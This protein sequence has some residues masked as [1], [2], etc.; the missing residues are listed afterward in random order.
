MELQEMSVNGGHIFISPYFEGMVSV[1]EEFNLSKEGVRSCSDG[2]QNLGGFLDMI[3]YVGGKDCKPTTF[4]TKEI[5]C[6]ADFMNT[7]DS[8]VTL[9]LYA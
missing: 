4:I 2:D 8:M 6:C 9:H 3:E 1:G 5:G 7:Q